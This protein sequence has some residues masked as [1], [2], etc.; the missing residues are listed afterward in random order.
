[1]TVRDLSLCHHFST[2]IFLELELLRLL[3]TASPFHIVN[4]TARPVC[5]GTER[6]RPL[7]SLRQ[8]VRPRGPSSRLR[9]RYARFGARQE[10]GV[11]RRFLNPGFRNTVRLSGYPVV[12]LSRHLL[13][14]GRFA[15]DSRTLCPPPAFLAAN[16]LVSQHRPGDPRRLV[17]EGDDTTFRWRDLRV[18]SPIGRAACRARPRQGGGTRSVDQLSAQVLLARACC[19]GLPPVVKGADTEPGQAMRRDRGRG[20]GSSA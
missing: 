7:I 17:G 5:K 9:W 20:R 3:W 10:L 16:L 19:L 4:R 1:M 15:S 18:P 14:H 2:L 6:D 13:A 8:R 11:E 12:T